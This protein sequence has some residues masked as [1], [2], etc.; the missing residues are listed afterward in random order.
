VSSRLRAL[1]REH[2]GSAAS[3]VV[4]AIAAKAILGRVGTFDLG[5]DD[6]CYILDA[7]L[8][9][10]TRPLPPAE[11]GA[12]YAVWYRVLGALEP[13]PVGLY[14]FNWV[15]L[16][17]GL[18]ALLYALARRSGA[19]RL[20]AGLVTIAWS[21]SR[22][23]TVWPFNVYF[24]TAILAAGALA[25]TFTE[26]RL[27]AVT[28]LAITTA[29]ASF[30][31]PELAIPGMPLVAVAIVWSLAR[32]LKSR[33]P[34]ALGAAIGVVATIA[35]LVGIF[36]SPLGGGRSYFAF[37]QHYAWHR[38]EAGKLG[39]DPMS[40]Y[41]PIV[42]ADF[43]KARSISEAAREN[44]SA[45]AWHVGY[46]VRLLLARLA[47]LWEV[48]GYVPRAV[49]VVLA[50]AAGAVLVAGAFA[51]ARWRRRLS[52]HLLAWLPLW[53]PIGASFAA[54]VLLIHPRD[55]YLVPFSFFVIATL[56]SACGALSWP[57]SRLAPFLSP[58]GL[59][60]AT[61][62]LALLPTYRRGALP[63]LAEARKS[64][65]PEDWDGRNSVEALRALGLRGERVVLEPEFSRAV[66]ARIPFRWVP[67]DKKDRPFYAF[68]Q[69]HEIDV[70]IASPSLL[71]DHRYRDDP[72]FRSFLEE[73]GDRRG[74]V[75]TRLPRSRTIIAVRPK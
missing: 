26:D 21:L 16:Q 69:Q 38:V 73:G 1:A 15:V 30:V 17:L 33:R 31:R 48:A 47:W 19:P 11:Y 56:A 59:A 44:P 20:A 14:T 39:V 37:Q 74:F 61:A 34:R 50:P 63:S 18:A 43:P 5:F 23:V 28:V 24:S 75:L 62:L 7:G 35:A 67:K 71:D 53:I 58:A 46:N 60:A 72:E 13:E 8:G 9:L 70:V 42:T 36:G 52:P 65:R 25:T 32:A 4:L 12:L 64:A 41:Q 54:A 2:A 68:L 10:P 3:L 40:A 29:A 51:L 45:F 6:E 66:Y 49:K 55:H 22:A 57:E 27:V